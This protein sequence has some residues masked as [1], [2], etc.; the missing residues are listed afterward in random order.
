MKVLILIA[1]LV[2]SLSAF[3]EDL[4]KEAEIA[5]EEKPV[6]SESGKNRVL[7]NIARLN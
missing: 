4:S 5:A 3:S 2:F 1:P 7:E 6:A